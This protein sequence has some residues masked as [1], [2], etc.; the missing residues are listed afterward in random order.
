[1]TQESQPQPVSRRSFLKN[2]ALTAVAATAAGAGAAALTQRSQDKP[3]TIDVGQPA[4]SAALPTGQT[5]VSPTPAAVNDNADLLARLANAQAENVRLQAAL[6]AAQRELE[7]LRGANQSSGAAAE[8]LTLQLDAA[9]ERLGILGGLVALYEQLDDVD[10]GEALEDGVTAVTDTLA[11]LLG[12][13][14]ALTDGLDVGDRALA[15]VEAHLPLLQNGR[16]WLND[17]LER[18]RAFYDGVEAVLQNFVDSVG[19][20]L[21]MLENWFQEMRKWLPFG[22][23]QRAAD[24]MTALTHLVAETPN[25]LSGL[26]TNIA[27]PLDVWLAQD[28][29]A[30]RL[31]RTLVKPLREQVL[32]P[33]RQTIAQAEQ[34]QT[35]YR[36][37]V[38]APLETAV[39]NRRAIRE[40]IGA[41]RQQHQV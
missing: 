8:E 5:A 21:Q 41:Y 29:D 35:V 25:T 4:Y 37:R 24:V 40:Q 13:A 28:A 30:P 18:V 6:D 3:P 14:P 34:V 11:N 1:M 32:D 16:A 19:P 36:A 27:Q 20:F 9:H 2:A 26:D 12:L 38:A 39:A 15:E 31:Q 17:H 7:S 22:L 33:A 10:M 23:G